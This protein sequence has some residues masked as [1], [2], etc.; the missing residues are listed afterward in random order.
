MAKL[1]RRTIGS[2]IKSKV[3]GEQDYIKLRGDTSQD[4]IKALSLADP[5]KGLSLRLES[6]AS[7]LSSLEGAVTAGK[8][9]EDVAETIRERIGKIPDYVRF[10]IILLSEG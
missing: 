7:Q 5:K 4:L 10:E 8:L 1:K 6:K 2:V 3:A 9:S